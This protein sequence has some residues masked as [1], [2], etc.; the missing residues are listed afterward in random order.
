MLKFTKEQADW[1][2]NNRRKFNKAQKKLAAETGLP[3]DLYG[4]NVNQLEGN[5]SPLPKDAWGLWDRQFVEIQRD[6]L[7]VFSDLSSNSLGMPIGKLVHHFAQMSD[8]GSTNISLDGQS[9]AKADSAVISYHGTPVPIIDSVMKLGWRQV[10]A[11]QSDGVSLAPDMIGNHQ[12]KIAEKLEDL[13]LN[14]DSKIKVGSDSLYGLRNHPKRNT[15]STGVALKGASGANWVTEVVGLIEVLHSK[16]FYSP[17]TIYLNY[18]DWFYASSTDYSTQYGNKKILQA[19]KEIEGVAAI[20]PASRVP[21]NEM[22]GV[23]KRSDVVQVLSA[24]PPTT[25]PKTRLDA[26]D[27]YIFKVMAAA[28]VEIK[29]DANDQCG[30]VHS[31]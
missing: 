27:D 20:I 21:A 23:C 1:V 17:V 10:A 7:A 11:A 19:L 26:E 6:V 4:L 29:F 22:I 5:A 16:N 8:A 30:V 24:M 9:E 12:R 25:R 2:I 28:A 18:S 31:S 13:A 3:E 15:R 14:G